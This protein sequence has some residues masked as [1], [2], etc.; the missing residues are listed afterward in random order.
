MSKFILFKRDDV[1]PYFRRI[2]KQ[3]DVPES[4]QSRVKVESDAIRI[5]QKR[6]LRKGIFL[7]FNSN[8]IEIGNP[9]SDNYLYTPLGFV[10]VS[11]TLTIVYLDGTLFSLKSD[12]HALV[13]E[14]RNI[15]D[16][17]FDDRLYYNHV[18]NKVYSFREFYKEK[19]Q[20]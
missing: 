10:P 1:D 7:N 11:K 12:G 17:I 4:F 2:T 16:P 8:Q 15:D 14:T 9:F 13:R 5:D 19:I 6:I 20:C 18:T 3:S